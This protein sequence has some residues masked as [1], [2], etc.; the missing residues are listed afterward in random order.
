MRSYK[1]VHVCVYVGLFNLFAS[2]VRYW[3]KTSNFLEIQ[4]KIV[5]KVSNLSMLRQI[6]RFL[7]Y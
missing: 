6:E 3:F 4:W 1:H 7:V 2:D 5:E